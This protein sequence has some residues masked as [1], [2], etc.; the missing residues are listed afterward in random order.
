ML[1]LE[2][3]HRIVLARYGSLSDFARVQRSHMQIARL[4]HLPKST[5]QL[6]LGRFRR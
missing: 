1:S 6:T 3:R 2:D 5:V 4:L